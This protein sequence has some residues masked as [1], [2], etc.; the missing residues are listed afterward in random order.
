MCLG[1]NQA[2]T[3]FANMQNP[4]VI[5]SSDYG[6]IIV[7]NN[8]RYIVPQIKLDGYWDAG[9]IDF[10]KKLLEI[11]FKTRPVITFYDVGANIGTHALA[12][13]KTY[14]DRIMIRAFEPQR[15]MFHMMCGTLAINGL[16]N[17]YAYHHAVSDVDG[18]ELR[19][20][21]P[22]YGK[23][24]N[25]GGLEIIPAKI[26]D[27]QDMIKKGF[28][29]VKTIT[30]DSFHEK[31]D[32]IKLD[33]EGMEHK[34]LMGALN[35]IQSHRPICQVETVKTDADFV[36]EFFRAKNYHGFQQGGDLLA[37]PAEYEIDLKRS[38]RIF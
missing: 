4:N 36:I 27:N 28:E 9:G 22:D 24:N 11:Q 10:I 21:L 37:L 7:N 12:L 35:T 38:K 8:D 16:T 19:F 30:I 13:G 25:F 5:I 2:I 23:T 18:V 32:F 15:L 31:V 20:E 14:G 1:K 6:P 26:S 33:V 17:T 29:S 34:A 3:S